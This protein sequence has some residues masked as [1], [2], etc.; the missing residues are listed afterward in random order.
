[1][2]AVGEVRA[3]S[4]ECVGQTPIL[5]QHGARVPILGSFDTPSSGRLFGR[6]YGSSRTYN[7]DHGFTRLW[8]LDPA[9]GNETTTRAILARGAG[10][11]R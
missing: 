6:R 1:M 8:W 9:T 7:L 11:H 2:T 10:V 3:A 4:D 5:L